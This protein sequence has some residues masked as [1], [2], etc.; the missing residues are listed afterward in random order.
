[1]YV[2]IN[3]P[4]V[5]SPCGETTV[6]SNRPMEI[7]VHKSTGVESIKKPHVKR[8]KIR[9]HNVTQPVHRAKPRTT[10]NASTPI[11][12][13]KSPVHAAEAGLGAVQN[14]ETGSQAAQNTGAG[15]QAGQ[16]AGTLPALK[17]SLIKQVVETKIDPQTGF[18]II[19]PKARNRNKKIDD[20]KAQPPKPFYGVSRTVKVVALLDGKPAPNTI[21]EVTNNERKSLALS[22]TDNDGSALVPVPENAIL[23]RIAGQF[24]TLEPE[25]DNITYDIATGIVNPNKISPVVKKKRG[26]FDLAS[27]DKITQAETCLPA[28]EPAEASA[29]S[30]A[31]QYSSE[32]SIIESSPYEDSLPLKDTSPETDTLSTQTSPGNRAEARK[33]FALNIKKRRQLLLKLLFGL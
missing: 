26:R 20:K 29:D 4:R 33:R 10:G 17:A 23:L 16:N 28:E 24:V 6:N 21:V 22:F 14:T 31:E 9:R 15:S 27:G 25:M 2:T 13:E 3:D 18:R 11:P 32:D 30:S 8:H 12:A 5:F 1:M 7:T 19:P